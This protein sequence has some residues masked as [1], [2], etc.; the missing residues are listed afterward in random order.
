ML[1]WILPFLIIAASAQAWGQDE[2]LPRY[3][4][5][6]F[7]VHMHY[8][9]LSS[10]TYTPKRIVKTFEAEG[11]TRALLSSYPNKNSEKVY[12][13]APEKFVL[14]LMPYRDMDDRLDWFNKPECIKLVEDAL[15]A[16]K[17]P[18]S[19]MGEFILYDWKDA[20]QPAVQR[21]IQ[22]AK[23]RKMPLIVTTGPSGVKKIYEQYPGAKMLLTHAGTYAQSP[24]NG[25]KDLARLFDQ[26]PNL[27][28][29]I[30]QL[31]YRS[32][33]LDI[34][35]DGI[36]KSNW[37]ELFL[38]YPGRIMVGTDPLMDLD[39]D[40]YHDYIDWI[41]TWLAQLPK[42]VAKKLAYDNAD[43]FFDDCAARLV[44]AK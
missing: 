12:K 41:R 11:V 1:K 9:D 29:D 28:I 16:D 14:G 34:A 26:Y 35:P 40:E 10:D 8:H 22:L 21:L 6:I 31:D 44:P 5:K 4:L 36:L 3:N 18:Y 27:S 38:K 7:D 33:S 2:T 23:E 20:K 15:S 42:G 30:A 13:L 39:W 43:R 25:P 17:S 32:E 24:I 37:K 19:V